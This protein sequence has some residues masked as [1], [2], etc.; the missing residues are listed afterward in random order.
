M[1]S[2]SK[3][4]AT[5]VNILVTSFDAEAN[6]KKNTDNKTLTQHSSITKS[7]AIVVT[8]VNEGYNCD[9]GQVGY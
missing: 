4:T 2:N 5:S 9:N 6:T 8:A 7:G 3:T 1:Q